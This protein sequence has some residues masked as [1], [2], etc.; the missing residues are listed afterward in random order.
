MKVLNRLSLVFLATHCSPASAFAVLRSSPLHG[1]RRSGGR[2]HN[3]VACSA[4]T[5]ASSVEQSV[6]KLKRVLEREYLSFFDPMEREYYAPSVTFDDPLTDLEG[7]DAYQSNVDMLA[8]RNLV[9]SL[10]FRDA[11][12]TLHSV[13][14]G[15]VSRA[16]D[17]VSISPIL[18]RWT[19]R[20]TFQALPWSPSPRFSG[21][22]RYTVAPG[23][24]AGCQVLQQEDFWDSI[25]LVPGGTYKKV[26]RKDAIQHFVQQLTPGNFEAPSAGPEL[27]YQTLRIGKGYEVRRYPSYTAVRMQYER[28]DEAFSA[29]GSFTNGTRGS[30]DVLSNPCCIASHL[31]AFFTD[32]RFEAHGP[33]RVSSQKWIF[34][35][36]NH[37]VA[38]ELC[39]ARGIESY[40][41]PGCCGTRHCQ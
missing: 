15:D 21:I 26:D 24:P 2:H 30:F 28:R 6:A 36:Q 7:V 35:E 14:G 9:G 39:T 12:I 19:L 40:S 1:N 38:L 31:S 41:Q 13:T 11:S 10:L 20:F 17:V 27:P 23:G 5:S 22:S 18:T 33:G 16:K 25:N 37:A 34:D 8:G 32:T 4:T 3:G 29:M